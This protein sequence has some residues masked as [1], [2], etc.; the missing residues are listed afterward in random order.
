MSD[1]STPTPEPDKAATPIPE[2]D[3]ADERALYAKRFN[4]LVVLIALG[5]SARSCT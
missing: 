1:A 2:P 4:T 3:K 5:R